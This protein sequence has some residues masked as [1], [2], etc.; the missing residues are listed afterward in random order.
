MSLAVGLF[1]SLSW[2][3]ALSWLGLALA[4]LRGMPS[5]PDLTR[6]TPPLDLP[7]IPNTSPDLAVVVPACD[8]EQTIAATL[9]SL[10][11]STGLRLQII[12]VNDRSTDR[13]GSEMARAQSEADA[14]RHQ[15]EILTVETLPE[16]WLGKP[17]AMAL[18]ASR[19][20][21]PWLL[22]TDGDVLFS[23]DALARAL[24]YVQAER[25]DHLVLVPTLIV[26]SLAERAMQFAMQVVALWAIRL[27]RVANPR[28]RDFVGVGGFNLIR[29]EAYLAVGGFESLRLEV[30]D[31]LRIGWKIKRA[32]L[33]QRV[34]LGPS[35]V[36]I[37]WIAGALSVVKLIE[38]NG[39]STYRF[40]PILHVLVSL[41]LASAALLPLA[42]LAA[43]SVHSPVGI[44]AAAAGAV[45]ALGI[46]LAYRAHR[47]LTQSPTWLAVFFAPCIA[48]VTYAFLRSMVLALARGGI[49]WR[50]TLYP[51]ALLRRNAGRW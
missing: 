21:A 10:L 41:G 48:V 2:L 24:R 29:R 8:E 30:L 34:A 22:F 23:P 16:G 38:K 42:D 6:E 51:L 39:F 7:K 36:R 26:H 45:S 43:I 47:R 37:R 15:L 28:A 1:L 17:H 31:D 13:T 44:A 33:R 11:G 40:H 4:A 18:A 12:A 5:L 3:L 27:W 20:Q 14:A 50:G 49:L 32:G 19:A 46:L 9:R 25:A 35:L